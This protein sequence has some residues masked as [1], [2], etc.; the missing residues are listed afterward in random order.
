MG[1]E[2]IKKM[3]SISIK[4]DFI[5]NKGFQFSLHFFSTKYSVEMEFEI[6][7]DQRRRV[8]VSE[9]CLYKKLWIGQLEIL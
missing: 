1:V 7:P 5:A 4:L 2:L 8:N 6:I 3:C 9:F